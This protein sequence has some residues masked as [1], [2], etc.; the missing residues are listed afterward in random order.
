MHGAC[1]TQAGSACRTERTARNRWPF[2]K[3][4][5]FAENESMA[6]SRW[7]RPPPV[8]RL[9]G[10]QQSAC[11]RCNPPRDATIRETRA[12]GWMKRIGTHRRPP[13]FASPRPSEAYRR[14]LLPG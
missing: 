6:I 11:N 12:V 5:R 3:K 2:L 7:S 14:V 8:P 1:Q 9:T 13:G 4:R 10:L